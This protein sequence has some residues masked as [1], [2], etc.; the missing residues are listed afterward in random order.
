ME[1]VAL[2]LQKH[3]DAIVAWLLTSGIRILLILVLAAVA[4]RLARVLTERLNSFM[5]GLTDSLERQKRA[6]T[7]SHI[8]RTIALTILL[9]VTTMTVLGE[10]GVNLAPVLAAAGIGGLAVGFGAQNLVRDVITGFFI[11]LE[12]QI[13]VG[14]IVKVGD[15]AGLVEHISLRVLTLRD[16]D[17]SVHLIPHGTIT[18]VTNMTKDCSYAVLDVGISSREDADTVIKILNDVGEE[19]RNDPLFASD[20][21]EDLEVVGIDSFSAARIVIKGRIKTAPIKQWRVAREFRRRLKKSFDHHGIE[22]P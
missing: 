20:I 2:T 11:L 18:T 21:L 8:V 19:L 14:D 7:L 10:I 6:R 13:R 5:Q 16:F 3:F 17:G 1:R 9:I 22:L 12:D 15:K 4:C